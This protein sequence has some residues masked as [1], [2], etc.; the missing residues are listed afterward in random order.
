MCL[1]RENSFRLVCEVIAFAGIHRWSLMLSV[2][3]FGVRRP[4]R[5]SFISWF[6]CRRNPIL[7]LSVLITFT[8]AA[9]KLK[10]KILI[11]HNWL[12]SYLMTTFPCSTDIFSRLETYRTNNTH[13]MS[14][15]PVHS[16]VCCRKMWWREVA[17][18]RTGSGCSCDLTVVQLLCIDSESCGSQ[19]RSNCS[20]YTARELQ[21]SVL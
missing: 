8:T 14:S 13:L 12:N 19:G 11:Q 1:D 18:V 20:H 5:W 4:Q 17:M 16:T 3:N 15:I 7:H 10:W 6:C 21:R 9:V 2:Y